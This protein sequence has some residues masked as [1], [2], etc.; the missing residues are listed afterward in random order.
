MGC[1]KG[2]KASDG[3]GFRIFHVDN[4][5]KDVQRELQVGDFIIKVALITLLTFHENLRFYM[6]Q[7]SI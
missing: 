2:T 1:G 7:G 5:M 6:L 4:L 3:F